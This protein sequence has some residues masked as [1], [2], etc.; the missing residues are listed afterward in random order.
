[1]HLEWGESTVRVLIIRPQRIKVLLIIFEIM[2]S[3]DKSLFF[4]N[5]KIKFEKKIIGKASIV[6]C[7]GVYITFDITRQW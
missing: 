6:I 7:I 2:F 4:S 3:H 1:M 5:L